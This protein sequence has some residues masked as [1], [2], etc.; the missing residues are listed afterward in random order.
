MA[1]GL[2]VTEVVA[3]KVSDVEDLGRA[4]LF[5]AVLLEPGPK[6]GHFAASERPALF[7][8]ELRA[9]FAGLRM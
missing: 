3:L 1:P 5:E 2:R 6:G 8:A 7:A 4:N 9:C